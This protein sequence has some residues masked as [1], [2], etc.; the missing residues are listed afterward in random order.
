M[1]PFDSLRSCSNAN[2]V[3]QRE[4]GRRESQNVSKVTNQIL[5]TTLFILAN[6]AILYILLSDAIPSTLNL[7]STPIAKS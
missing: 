3:A 4:Q 2:S 5:F 6:L 7:E 1:G